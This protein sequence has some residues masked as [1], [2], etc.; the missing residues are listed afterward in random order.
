MV[1]Q[2]NSGADKLISTIERLEKAYMRGAQVNIDGIKVTSR[3]GRVADETTR[4]N[5]SLG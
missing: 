5:F 2:S 3:I 1:A 4:N